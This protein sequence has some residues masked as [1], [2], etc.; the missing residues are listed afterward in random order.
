MK[1]LLI[2][3]GNTRLKWAEA[4]PRRAIKMR[5]HV[6]T[7]EVTPRWAALLAGKIG[8][9]RVIVC[10]VVPTVTQLLRRAF[11]D[12]LFVDGTLK[13]LPL[14]FHYPQPGEI[15]A[16]RIAATIGA[17]VDGPVIIVSCGTATAFSVLD[18]QSRFCGGAI[19]P[20]VATQLGALLGATAQLP[21][22]K[23]GSN[24][25]ALGRSTRAAIRAGVVLG[26]RGGVREIIVHL[27]KQLG[28]SARVVI[29]GGE[30]AHL[31]GLC[32]IGRVE[33]RPLLVFEGLRII[34]D[35]LFDR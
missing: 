9:H 1:L 32:G 14:A 26:Y 20:G 10:S 35:A 16:D 13:G 12:G 8:D 27:R 33:F 7:K 28:V 2:D 29:T 17:A 19:M 5:G 11:P 15:G 6:A 23:L 24:P 4:E 25:P 34:A 30:A 3:V 21:V 31:R 22:T 18:R